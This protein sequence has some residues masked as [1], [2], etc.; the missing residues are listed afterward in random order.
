[1]ALLPRRWAMAR[2]RSRRAISN[3]AGS[4][5][6]LLPMDEAMTATVI[7]RWSTSWAS[8]ANSS[9][10]KSSTFFPH[11]LRN[12][13]VFIPAACIVWRARA[14]SGWISSANAASF[15]P[16]RRNR[17]ATASS[18]NT[19]YRYAHQYR[20]SPDSRHS[21]RK[22]DSF[23]LSVPM[24]HRRHTV[25]ACGRAAAARLYTN[26]RAQRWSSAS[27]SSRPGA[28]RRADRPLCPVRVNCYR[29]AD[30][31]WLAFALYVRLLLP[32]TSRV[33]L[34]TAGSELF[35][36]RSALAT[37]GTAVR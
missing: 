14:G 27:P 20:R 7:P 8:A 26:P 18:L 24:F 5:I 23:V 15:Q 36:L 16:M 25:R 29:R 30:H 37:S 4:A 2:A 9:S 3:A 6:E 22:E 34:T 19:H 31:W 32:A 13:T 21:V 11:A 1:M 35:S 12:S 28:Q 33:P 17:L 10:V